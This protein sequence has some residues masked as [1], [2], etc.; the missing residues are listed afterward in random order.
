MGSRRA[1]FS[2]HRRDWRKTALAQALEDGSGLVKEGV[3]TV[4]L[5][6][7]HERQRARK[8]VR[9]K[10]FH[11]ALNDTWVRRDRRGILPR[12][13]LVGG[14]RQHGNRQK[15]W[16]RHLHASAVAQDITPANI[17]LDQRDLLNGQS[18]LCIVLH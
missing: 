4:V 15:G 7:A 13:L 18:A 2:G 11:A 6:P 10:K 12:L 16:S 1:R 14:G 9:C 8:H 5:A 3:G 17:G